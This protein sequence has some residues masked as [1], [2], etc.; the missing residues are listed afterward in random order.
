MEQ[1]FSKNPW[2]GEMY[3]PTI[4]VYRSLVL[5]CLVTWSWVGEENLILT[6]PSV[7]PSIIW[8][9]NTEH[10]IR[11]TLNVISFECLCCSRM[12]GHVK[13]GG[14]GEPDPDPL[15][16]LVVTSATKKKEAARSYDPK[17]SVW[18]EVGQTGIY[19]H[20]GGLI[21]Q[22]SLVIFNQDFVMWYFLDIQIHIL[23]FL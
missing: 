14:G 2:H 5:G 21:V 12:P 19:W 17:R 20:G 10:I 16:F 8:I 22:I 9:E 13:L 3:C 6:I 4:N 7:T 15:P 1:G 23:F 18:A 11:S